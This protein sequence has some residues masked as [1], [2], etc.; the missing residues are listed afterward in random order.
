MRAVMTNAGMANAATGDQ[1]YKDAV[2]CANL[3]AKALGVTPDDVLLQSTGVIGRRMKMEAFVPAIPEL[4]K[5]L[6]SSLEHGHRAGIA[7]TTTDLVSKTA[8]LQVWGQED[9]GR[10]W[11]GA[12]ELRKHGGG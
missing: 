6:G 8:A 9:W 12:G 4:V 10:V 7:I 5:T 1:G 3:A 11:V 2:E